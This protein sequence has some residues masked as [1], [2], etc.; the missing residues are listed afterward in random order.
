MALAGGSKDGDMVTLEVIAKA[1]EEIV[2]ALKGTYITPDDR[3]LPVQGDITKAVHA[4]GMS[5]VARKLLWNVAA[6]SKDIGGT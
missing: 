3:R 2:K 1:S 5:M 6:V 4:P